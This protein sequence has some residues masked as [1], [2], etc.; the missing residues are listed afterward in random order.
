VITIETVAPE[1]PMAAQIV[2]DYMSDVVSRWY[3]RPATGDELDQA[4]R[5]E[6]SDD[7]QG[8]TGMLL[9]AVDGERPVGCAGVRFLGSAAELTKVFTSPSHRG[10]GVG[11]QLLRAV[12][13][14]CRERAVGTLRL[15]TRA[16]LTE[17]CAMYERNGF[18]R[19][20]AFNNEPYSDRWYSKTLAAAV[21]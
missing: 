1:S 20:G 3:G 15:D 8:V 16:A 13:R 2:H 18:E 10:R 4:L 21:R 14:A 12:E 11:S 19:V 7:L 17:A 6:P 5:D 9:V